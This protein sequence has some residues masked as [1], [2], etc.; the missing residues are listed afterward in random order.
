[1]IAAITV[2]IVCYVYGLVTIIYPLVLT[3]CFSAIFLAEAIDAS[4]Q[5]S[6]NPGLKNVEESS[7]W[8]SRI[9]NAWLYVKDKEGWALYASFISYILGTL[10]GSVFGWIIT[11]SWNVS[12]STSFA[13]WLSG[14]F[15]MLSIAGLIVTSDH[16]SKAEECSN[17]SYEEVPF[18]N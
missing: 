18:L 4:F 11:N 6:V 15:L 12:S 8:F 7:F 14:M 5:A 13:S 3:L 17:I 1:L 16:W 2:L 9:Y 10:L